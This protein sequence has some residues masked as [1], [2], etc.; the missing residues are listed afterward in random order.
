MT[1]KKFWEGNPENI[2]GITKVIGNVRGIIEGFRGKVIAVN[3][4]TNEAI[5]IAENGGDELWGTIWLVKQVD[6]NAWMLLIK[7]VSQIPNEGAWRIL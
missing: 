5:W 2:D 1:E 6:E 7:K 3:E 4:S